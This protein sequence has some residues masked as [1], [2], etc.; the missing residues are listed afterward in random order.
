MGRSFYAECK[1]VRNAKMKEELG[2]ALKHPTYRDG[3]QAVLSEQ[4]LKN[5]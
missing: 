2:V 1:R 3:L 5:A 4:G